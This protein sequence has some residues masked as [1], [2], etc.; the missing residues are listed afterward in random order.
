MT[1]A[2]THHARLTSITGTG[3]WT[4]VPMGM[5]LTFILMGML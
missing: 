1:R 3:E 4:V 5:V 2:F